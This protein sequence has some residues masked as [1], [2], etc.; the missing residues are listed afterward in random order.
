M[1]GHTHS[2]GVRD[3]EFH[4]DPSDR[5]SLCRGVADIGRKPGK[6]RDSAVEVTV[7]AEQDVRLSHCDFG[8]KIGNISVDAQQEGSKSSRSFGAPGGI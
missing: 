7:S 3:I 5:R 6:G 8:M 2:A 1:A 4:R